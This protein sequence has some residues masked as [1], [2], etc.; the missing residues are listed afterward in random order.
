[1]GDQ[2]LVREHKT[3]V[4]ALPCDGFIGPDE[5][6]GDTGDGSLAGLGGALFVEVDVEG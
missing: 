5:A 3:E 2:R 4:A 6:V 1:L